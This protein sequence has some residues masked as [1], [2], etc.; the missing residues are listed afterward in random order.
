VTTVTARLDHGTT[1]HIRSVRPGGNEIGA[2][3]LID[4]DPAAII[5]WAATP[6]QDER[7]ATTSSTRSAGPLEVGRPYPP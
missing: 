5:V 1:L 6:A 2:Q 4:I 7:H 3:C